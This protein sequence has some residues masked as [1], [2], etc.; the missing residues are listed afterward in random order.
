[1]GY[2]PPHNSLRFSLYCVGICVAVQQQRDSQT[3][4]HSQTWFK[5]SNI[6]YYFSCPGQSR[7]NLLDSKF[8]GRLVCDWVSTNTYWQSCV[9]ALDS[10]L[11]TCM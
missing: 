5:T 7:D 10:L 1:M 11:V 2:N 8:G 4:Q 6:V 3:S 9:I